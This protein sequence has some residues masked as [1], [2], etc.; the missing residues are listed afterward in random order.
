M[1]LDGLWRPNLR[2][3]IEA[4][5]ARI[6]AGLVSKEEVGVGGPGEGGCRAGE[7]RVGARGR[8]R[9]PPLATFG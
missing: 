7:G 5:I 1:G 2:A 3:R 8:C 6:A 9:P 4:G